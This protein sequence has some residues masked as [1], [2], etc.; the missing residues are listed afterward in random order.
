MLLPFHRTLIAAL[1]FALVAS[2]EVAPAQ[3]VA[4]KPVTL[5]IGSQSV[6]I[7]TPSGFVETSRRSP[8]LWA[9]ALSFGAGDARIIAHFVTRPDLAE[10]EKG[11]TVLFKNFLLVQTPRRAESLVVTQAQFDKLRAGTVSLQADLGRRLKPRLASELDR[12]SKAV[13]SNQAAN[14]TVRLGE[15]VPV[16][17]DRNESHLL[18]YTI[19]AQGGI[20][21]GKSNTSQTSV[22]STAYCFIA[23]KVVMLVAYQHFR[24]P[25]DLQTARTQ[26]ET[27]ANAVLASN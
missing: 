20:S 24:T 25:Q 2:Q 22:A 23:G 8:E 12:V 3:T 19:L 15:I 9:T 11:K 10:Y 4:A 14:I 6:H 26:V 16:S 13:W 1:A 21:E 17:V 5:Q 18:I 27:W 7:P